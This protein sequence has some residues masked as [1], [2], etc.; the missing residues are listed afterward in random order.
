MARV[1]LVS[2]TLVLAEKFSIRMATRF[3]RQLRQH[4]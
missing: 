4:Q 2:I 1:G 3:T